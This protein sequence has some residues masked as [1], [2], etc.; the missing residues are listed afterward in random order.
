MRKGIP[1]TNKRPKGPAPACKYC[2]KPLR[3]FWKL[4]WPIRSPNAISQTWSGY[5]RLGNGFFCSKDCG[6]FF[7]IDLMNRIEAGRD[8]K[9]KA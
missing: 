2:G 4:E 7:A 3:S 5:G 1:K 6:Y 8:G 9:G